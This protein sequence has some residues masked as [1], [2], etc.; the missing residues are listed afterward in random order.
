MRSIASFLKALRKAVGLTQV[1]AARGILDKDS[2]SQIECGK[3]FPHA[4]HFGPLLERYGICGYSLG[5]FFDIKNAC[6][7]DYKNQILSCMQFK[8][9]G[10][11][12]GLLF[13]FRSEFQNQSHR[14]QKKDVFS[15]QFLSYAL[16]W[17]N[18]M[19][20]GSP[21]VFLKVCVKCLKMT[22]PSFGPSFPIE[23]AFLVQNEL[24][25]LNSIACIL[26]THYDR[27]KA[28]RLFGQL[29]ACHKHFTGSHPI[30]FRNYACL[31]H[32]TALIEWEYNPILARS[33]MSRAFSLLSQYGGSWT[34]CLVWRSDLQIKGFLSFSHD[35]Q[36]E[37]YQLSIM[38]RKFR[39]PYMANTSFFE[40]FQETEFL[41]LF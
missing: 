38:Y 32:N 10:K 18:Y 16:E 4:E 31:L 27:K 22:Q 39:P 30:Y 24:M 17:Y 25:I 2:L 26:A 40:F 29:L 19:N 37:K 8:E 13:S 9:F 41:E 14:T 21:D 3:H 1:E 15:R 34:S 23:K 11:L 20:G 12:P 6:L 33:H 28:L 35:A 7:I 36:R 5:D